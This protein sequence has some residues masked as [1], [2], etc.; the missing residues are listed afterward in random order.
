MRCLHAARERK[1]EVVDVKVDDVEFR[2][3]LDYLLEHQNVVHQLVDAVLVHPQREYGMRARHSA[4]N[5]AIERLLASR[6]VASIQIDT[7]LDE[8]AI[9]L[10][11]PAGVE[12]LIARMDV[13]VT[14]RLHGLVLAIRNGVPV[15]AVDA[16][17]GGAKVSRQ[18]EIIGW[19]IVSTVEELS[20][21][22]LA[23]ALDYC[24]TGEAQA[25]ARE[26][27]ERALKKLSDLKQQF[28]ASFMRRD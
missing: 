7:R 14:T 6:D 9:G 19:P 1:M 2:R 21:K 17:A 5:E 18:A 15:I 13:V 10:R 28:L 12:S 16:I 8:N 22:R 4:V 11:S 23:N 20:D 3:A 24:L 26:C 25:K 27:R